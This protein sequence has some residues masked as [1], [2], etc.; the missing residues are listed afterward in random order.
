[1][2]HGGTISVPSEHGGLRRKVALAY[3]EATTAGLSHQ[4][5]WQ[6]AWAVYVTE[7]GEPAPEK[8]SDTTLYVDRLIASAIAIDAEWFWRPVRERV[9]RGE[10]R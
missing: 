10:V 5:S 8:R 9:E 4:A 3:R 7:R 6:R 2:T 1:M